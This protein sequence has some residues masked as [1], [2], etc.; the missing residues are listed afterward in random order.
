LLYKDAYEG[1]MLVKHFKKTITSY[2]IY[3]GINIFA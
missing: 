1:N 3:L 2:I